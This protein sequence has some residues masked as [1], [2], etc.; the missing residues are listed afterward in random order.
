MRAVDT[1]GWLGERAGPRVSSSSSQAGSS[2]SSAHAACWRERVRTTTT[3]ADRPGAAEGR[4]MNTSA[5]SSHW[6][7]D[8]WLAST[9]CVGPILDPVHAAASSV[10][11][12]RALRTPVRP[13]GLRRGLVSTAANNSDQIGGLTLQPFPQAVGTSTAPWVG[14]P[15]GLSST[16]QSWSTLAANRTGRGRGACRA[17]YA[18]RQ[19]I[20]APAPG[21]IA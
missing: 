10:T 13:R 1:I 18:A 3:P 4:S 15:E 12:R 16:V 20:G 7:R 9:S 5:A 11:R 21:R 14:T 6:S 2:S 19:A 8:W 17:M